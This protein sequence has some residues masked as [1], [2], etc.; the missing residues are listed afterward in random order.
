M[1]SARAERL[2]SAIT[3]FQ[4]KASALSSLGMSITSVNRIRKARE[5]DMSGLLNSSE[6][7]ILCLSCGRN[8]TK[9]IGWIKRHSDFVCACGSVT[10]L[11]ESHDIKSEIAKV[12]GLLSAHDPPSKFDIDRLPAD[13]LSGIDLII[14]WWGYLQFQLGVIIRKA[15]KLHNDTGRV[16]T[17]GPDLKVLCNIIGTLTH[18]DHWIKDKGIRDDLKKLIKDVRDNSEKRNDYAHGMFG[19]DE[20]KNVFIRHLLKTP[21]HRA[22]PGTEEMTVDTLGEASDQARDLWIRAHGIRGRLRT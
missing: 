17:Y 4:E 19:Y 20:K 3:W 2:R 6:V 15:M 12:E 9:S 7:P 18:S 22:T 14:G 13:I 5:I 16:L 11:D 21:A 8:T 1:R 10:K